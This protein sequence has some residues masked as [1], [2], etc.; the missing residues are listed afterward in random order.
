MALAVCMAL[1]HDTDSAIARAVRKAGSQSAFGRI[2]GKTQ[3]SVR[4]WLLAGQMPADDGLVLVVERE[5]GVSRHELRPDIYPHDPAAPA[6]RDLGT[7]EP[8]R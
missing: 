8:A 3:S 2:V 4:Q 7:M 5:T 1:E 6:Q